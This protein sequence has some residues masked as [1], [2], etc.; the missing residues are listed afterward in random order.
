MIGDG[1]FAV[2][3]ECVEH[4]TGRAYALK[5]I[6][7]GKCRGKVRWKHYDIVNKRHVFLFLWQ[8][9]QYIFILNLF[10]L[11]RSTWSRM[12]WLSSEEW[13]IQTL[14]CWLRKWTLTVNS[15]WSWSLL[16]CVLQ[17]AVILMHLF[18]PKRRQIQINRHKDSQKSSHSWFILVVEI[19]MNL[20]SW[21]VPVTAALCSFAGSVELNV[22][23]SCC[24]TYST[25][26][27]DF[28]HVNSKPGHRELSACFV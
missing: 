24:S 20:S 3:H 5:I 17:Q 8:F 27:G 12:K 28:C 10:L 18:K 1:N 23:L 15:T 26:W 14:C 21:W 16:R 22:I 19:R 7:K 25:L 6:N 11:H 2:V 4:S 13:N 9:V